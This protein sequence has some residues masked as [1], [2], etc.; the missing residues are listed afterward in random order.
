[1]AII[2]FWITLWQIKKIR[3]VADAQREAI[4]GLS[5]RLSQLDV[6]AE[7]TKAEAALGELKKHALAGNSDIPIGIFDDLATSFISIAEGSTAISDEVR[8]R[9]NSAI[10][11]INKLAAPSSRQRLEDRS[12]GK[13]LATIRDYRGI[14]VKIR[15][16]VH[17]GHLV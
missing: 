6:I 9:V 11:N 16:Q 15:A 12:A 4:A 14:I 5:F 3:T 10:S 7:C 17:E 1:L 8:A 2:G 13:Q